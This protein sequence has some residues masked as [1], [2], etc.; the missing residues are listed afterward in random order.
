MKSLAGRDC[1]S[2]LHC[3][4]L[5]C[6]CRCNNAPVFLQKEPAAHLVESLFGRDGDEAPGVVSP[7]TQTQS[8][9]I[10]P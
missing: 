8:M 2:W 1:R 4:S 9:P 6:H 3:V 5:G 7:E 10:P